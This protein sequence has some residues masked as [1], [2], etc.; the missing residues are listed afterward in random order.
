MVSFAI[1]GPFSYVFTRGCM[2]SETEN[3]SVWNSGT[4]AFFIVM[5]AF[6]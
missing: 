3:R 2:G 6:D 1:I 5:D 4:G